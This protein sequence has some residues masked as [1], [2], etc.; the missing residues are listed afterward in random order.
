[1]NDE[2]FLDSWKK[3]SAYLD[4]EVRTCRRWEKQLDLPVHRID[5]NSHR[6][7]VFAYKSEIDQW[8]RERAYN[9]KTVKGDSTRKNKWVILGLIFIIACLSTFLAISYLGTKPKLISRPLEP[10]HPS[11][12]VLPFENASTIKSD[13]YLSEG[14]TK[15]FLKNLAISNRIKLIQ[16][17]PL[18]PASIPELKRACEKLK[19]D[20]IL[21]GKLQNR[22]QTLILNVQLLQTQD[23]AN[24]WETKA[25]ASLKDFR[26]V[27]N[28]L[29]HKIHRLLRINIENEGFPLLSDN[30]NDNSGALDSY[31]K[32]N[33]I[34]S[35]IADDN[36]WM[37]YHQGKYYS[38]Q[39]T[40]ESNEFAIKL[41]SQAVET[42]PNFALAYIGLAQCY[43]NYVNFNWKFE[44]RWLTKAEDLIQKS[45]KMGP[46]PPEYYSTLMEIY[47]MR[48]VAFDENLKD[49][50]FKMAEEGIKKYPND[51]QLNSIVGYL[52]FLE[53][54]E[55][56]NEASFKKALEYKEKSFWL[57]PY[58]TGNIVFTEL[59]MLN[60]D[61]NRAA[62]V[63]NIIINND[64]S[65]MTKFRLGE[66]L[67]YSGDLKK[68]EETFR[69]IAAP[70][71][72]EMA[73]LLYLG[74]DFIAERR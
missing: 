69:D 34:L 60:R 9:G 37:L 74:Y 44:R 51:P 21:L 62:E 28:D 32:G 24:I 22:D 63:C 4:K 59:L 19:A 10:D 73:G 61:F 13:E 46:S 53:F 66:I 36:P 39:C 11:I 64:R 40:L 50:L 31:M 70:P 56:G 35:N 57:D 29:S 42:D 52:Y 12:A 17:P 6:S 48:H 49:D 33:Y 23:Y 30:G 16:I 15:E 1:M 72:Y 43:A 26:P 47:L 8:L 20:Y 55:G 38:G 14:M 67:Y 65:P 45:L 25:E 3:I 18:H 27:L 54:G 71:E 5:K 58:S 2:E 7:G 68:S 41:F